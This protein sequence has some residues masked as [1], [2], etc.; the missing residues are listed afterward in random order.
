[1]QRRTAITSP[2]DWGHDEGHDNQQAG[3]A[4]PFGMGRYHRYEVRDR[5]PTLSRSSSE[6]PQQANRSNGRTVQVTLSAA[7]RRRSAV[8]T[9]ARRMAGRDPNRSEQESERERERDS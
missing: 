4:E 7:D 1:M 6:R 2:T 9:G 5:R 8:T 3:G